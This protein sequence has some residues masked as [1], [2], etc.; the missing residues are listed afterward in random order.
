[1]RQ[2]AIEFAQGASIRPILRSLRSKRLEGWA[3]RCISGPSFETR[4]CGA[5]LRMRE[6]T[7]R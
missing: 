7:A 3:K 6:E 1:M 4:A 2:V 5:L